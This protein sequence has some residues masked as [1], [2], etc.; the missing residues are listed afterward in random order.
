MSPTS[1]ITERRLV[2]ALHF[3]GAA[4]DYHRGDPVVVLGPRAEYEDEDGNTVIN[5]AVLADALDHI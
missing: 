2:D 5:V 3:I 1:R 4:V